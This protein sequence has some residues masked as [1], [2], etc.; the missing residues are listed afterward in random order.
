MNW[1]VFL[2]I[3][4]LGSFFS[5]FRICQR[6]VQHEEVIDRHSRFLEDLAKNMI[7]LTEFMKK[8]KE[9]K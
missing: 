6:M 3:L 7:A 8:E 2:G 4:V 9:N 5:I 1:I